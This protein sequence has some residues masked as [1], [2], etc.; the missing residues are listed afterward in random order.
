MKIRREQPADVHQIREILLAAFD[1]N[2]EAD[3]VDRLRDS[4]PE[5]ISM[6]AEEDARLVG[7]IL[8]SPVVVESADQ[9]LV[10]M[11]LAPMSVL[12]A[13]QRQGVGAKLVDAGLSVLREAGHP[14]V[15]VIGHPKYYPR[16]GFQPASQFHLTCEFQVPDN[17]FM[18]LILDEN[19]SIPGGL[20][21]YHHEFD[22]WK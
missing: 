19:C 3:L 22:R 10:G 16:F 12:P 2:D 17:A 18:A 14:F 7:H 13:C 5:A 8:F 11:G 20:A 6:V 21:E 4:C 1:G 9:E 15:I